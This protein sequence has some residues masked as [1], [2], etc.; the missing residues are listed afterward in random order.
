MSL[1][2]DHFLIPKPCLQH[3]LSFEPTWDFCSPLLLELYNATNARF[4]QIII[5]IRL[6]KPAI[7]PE[8]LSYSIM[9]P[10]F[11]C[12]GFAQTVQY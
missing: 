1:T 6:E 3:F 9:Q 10:S 8:V 2:T 11:S 7:P 4:D 5:I 12:S